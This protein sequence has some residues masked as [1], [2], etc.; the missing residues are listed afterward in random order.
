MARPTACEMLTFAREVCQPYGS[1]GTFVNEQLSR[2]REKMVC[3][4]AMSCNIGSAPNAHL[5]T[6]HS[7]L[8]EARCGHS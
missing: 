5:P 7:E 6:F 2:G 4:F 1:R 3:V 8:G